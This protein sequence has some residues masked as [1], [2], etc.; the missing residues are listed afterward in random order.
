MAEGM[1]G[2]ILGDDD[3]KPEIEASEALASAD[4]DPPR[5]RPS[6]NG[7]WRYC[8][9]RDR[10]GGLRQGLRQP[11]RVHP[12]PRLTLLDCAGRGSGG[13]CGQGRCIPEDC[14]H[15]RRLLSLPRRHPRRPRRLGRGAEG[16]C[17]GRCSRPR[18]AGGVVS[19]PSRLCQR[20]AIG[21][22]NRTR[23][24]G[25]DPPGW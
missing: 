25:S 11:R 12:E 4:A 22:R 1:L 17:R 20:R 2:G 21:E 5:A 14:G 23:R 6:C 9:G 7:G 10:D 19:Q 3:E 8:D 18:L 13:T 24:V 15:V 16:V